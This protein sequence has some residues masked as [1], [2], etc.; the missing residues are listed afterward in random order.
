MWVSWC[1]WAENCLKYTSQDGSESWR[2]V[3]EGQVAVII[4]HFHNLLEYA[5]VL[6]SILSPS[7]V[8]WISWGGCWVIELMISMNFSLINWMYEEE[9]LWYESHGFTALWFVM[10][11]V[12]PKLQSKICVFLCCDLICYSPEFK[13]NLEPLV[14]T[15]VSWVQA[16][17]HSVRPVEYHC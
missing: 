3:W 6:H 7:N 13:Q 11:V 2:D 8:I 14:G 16:N 17:D 1:W 9:N 5:N 10:K 12:T 15:E 4:I